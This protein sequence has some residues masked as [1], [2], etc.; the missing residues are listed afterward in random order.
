[1]VLLVLQYNSS[2]IKNIGENV[3]KDMIANQRKLHLYRLNS[4]LYSVL[5][6]IN[7]A[8][9]SCIKNLMRNVIEEITK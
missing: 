5:C 1:M 3:I 6:F 9:N 4:K 7:F 2:Y 8:I